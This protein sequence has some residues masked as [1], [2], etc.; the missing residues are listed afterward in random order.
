MSK[1]EI[2]V[3]NEIAKDANIAGVFKEVDS[4]LIDKLNRGTIFPKPL[5]ICSGGTTSRCAANNHWTLDLRENYQQ[6]EFNSSTNVIE[7]S[8][9]IKMQEM[10][11]LLDQYSRSFPIGLS[12]LPGIGYIINGGISPISRNKGLAIDQILHIEGV[13]GNG[14][15]FSLSKP[16][17]ESDEL[18]LNEWRALC[19]A[20]CFLGIITKFKLKTYENKK[21]YV[22]QGKL[23]SKELSE[24]ILK[25]E[26]WP[27]SASLQWI[28]GKEIKAYITIEIDNLNIYNFIEELPLKFPSH[29]KGQ[30]YTVNGISELPLFSLYNQNE[31]LY[32]NTYSE[33]ISL[34][35]PK[36]AFKS[37]DI[38]KGLEVLISKRPN[39]E[40]YIAAQQLGG[41]VSNKNQTSF[42][43]RNSMWK[44][45]ISGSWVKGSKQG[46]KE[47]LAWMEEV[48][49]HLEPYCPGVHLAQMHQHLPWHKKEILSAY[50]EFLP[51]LKEL[52]KIHD[53]NGNLPFL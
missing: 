33:I 32:N 7:I 45:W 42:I 40:C 37:S 52:K 53:P 13:W 2:N 4:N 36:W 31:K 24:A 48:W 26:N 1:N 28:W 29:N 50:G 22:W 12:G 43:H 27:N 5:L 35:G 41:N 18:K 8:A 23:S 19:G 9:G 30:G 14:E 34:I 44:P 47:S 38:V 51:I 21:I 39:S 25:S 16:N 10:Q 46:R 17:N 11:H 3:Q 49:N 20:G 15:K 6:M